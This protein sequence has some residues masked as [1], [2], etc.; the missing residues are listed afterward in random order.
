MFK[1]VLRGLSVSH[2]AHGTPGYF[3]K[4]LQ[5]PIYKDSSEPNT[6]LLDP[7]SRL[8]CPLTILE[9]RCGQNDSPPCVNPFNLPPS[10]LPQPYS[11]GNPSQQPMS[12]LCFT[13]CPPPA[14]CD[15]YNPP[16]LP[17]PPPSIFGPSAPC[18]STPQCYSFCY[19]FLSDRC[20]NNDSRC[21]FCC[22]GCPCGPFSTSNTT[23][24]PCTTL[25]PPCCGPQFSLPPICRPVVNENRPDLK[26]RNNMPYPPVVQTSPPQ[27]TPYPS[28]P[29]PEYFYCQEYPCEFK[30]RLALNSFLYDWHSNVTLL[31]LCFDFAQRCVVA[32]ALRYRF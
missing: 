21:H 30:L 5:N 18:I 9:P 32:V 31:L 15:P 25:C 6:S 28:L 26:S 27:N 24:E 11:P 16:S 10:P 29:P 22:P 14:I 13:P 19:Q 3:S 8:T 23:S 7:N 4:A 2:K 12:D 20:C 1:I 17:L